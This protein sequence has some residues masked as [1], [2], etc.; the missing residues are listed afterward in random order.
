MSY[1]GKFHPK[2]PQKYRGDSSKIT[3]RS[4]W[5]LKFFRFLD[6]HPDVIWWN[7]EETVIPYTSPIDGRI[8]RYYPD[9]LLKKKVEDKEEI[10]M[11]EIKPE[12]QTREPD[13]RK[14]NNTPSGRIS[15]R[16]L[17]EVKT[18]GINEAKWKSAEKYCEQ[19]GWKFLILTE[20]SLG[21][22]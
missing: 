15:R 1:K 21:I 9:V 14:K 19:K 4:G 13:I 3:Y 7:S 12:G 20:K 8:H 5:E 10:F 16:Y 17:N 11:I 22:K 18:Y 6:N 2:N